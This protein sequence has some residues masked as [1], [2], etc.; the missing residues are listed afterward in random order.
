M[1]PRD[2]YC[3]ILVKNV[4]AFCPFLK[5]VPKDKVIHFRMILLAEE[6]SKQPSIDSVA[7]LFF[8]TLTNIYNEREQAEQTKI[9]DVQIEERFTREWTRVKFCVHGGE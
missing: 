4:V 6:I 3:D 7:W 2:I 5:S 9:Q 1:W 8:L